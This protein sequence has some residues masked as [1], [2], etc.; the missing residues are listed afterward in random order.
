M[1]IVWQN[2]HSYADAAVTEFETK[3]SEGVVEGTEA[4]QIELFHTTQLLKHCH[5]RYK[6]LIDSRF[7]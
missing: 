2:K 7:S 1:S 6:L 5:V 4:T 3:L